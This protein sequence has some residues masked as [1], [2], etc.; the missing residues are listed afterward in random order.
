MDAI[1]LKT[2]VSDWLEICSQ[3]ESYDSKLSAE[4]KT[5]IDY[6]NN[7]LTNKDTISA[8]EIGK[9]AEFCEL[10]RRS[11]KY[12]RSDPQLATCTKNFRGVVK[13]MFTE[14]NFSEF[15][16][17]LKKT[18]PSSVSKPTG[19][20]Y[21]PRANV[22]TTFTPRSQSQPQAA[23]QPRPQT[24]PQTTPQPRPQQINIT[25][26]PTAVHKPTQQTPNP[27]N[28]STSGASVGMKTT[29]GGNRGGCLTLVIIIVAL[30]AIFKLWPT[31]IS[32]FT[33]NGDDDNIS[34]DTEYVIGETMNI[35]STPDGEII[36]KADYG[37]PV[38]VVEST[39]GEW[40]KVNANGISGY[41]SKSGLCSETEYHHLTALWG[42]SYTRNK[43]VEMRYRKALADFCV[44]NDLSAGYK[45]YGRE[46]NGGNIWSSKN[47]G[48][49]FI[50]D[51][52]EYGNR[53]A[54]V[55]S[56]DDNN[57]FK[58]ELKD[59]EVGNDKYIKRVT[60]NR[61][62]KY[63]IIYGTASNE[64]NTEMLVEE[65]Q[66]AKEKEIGIMSFRPG[67]R[68]EK[69][70][71][72]KI[73]I[74]ENSTKLYGEYFNPSESGR[75]WWGKGA[76]ILLED[77]QHLKASN[78]E[79]IPFEPQNAIFNQNQH[80]KFVL[81]FPPL[82]SGTTQFDFFESEGSSGWKFYDIMLSDAV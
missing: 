10:L 49:A 36:G 27:A 15:K 28:N 16:A 65:P 13:K 42:D 71:L 32:W 37:T 75:V 19:G 76:F 56:F 24:R 44:T 66:V 62:G 77:G 68:A 64:K 81:T 30:Y 20:T 22:Q 35:R 82:P 9:S 17:E 50:L 21:T 58:C 57:N 53:I 12:H 69:C 1:L 67:P 38:V 48:F 8:E 40:K 52:K 6:I 11:E 26:K 46:K 55:Y 39:L 47:V 54:A 25:P 7:L 79:G 41:I 59:S 29:S 3:L 60:V 74:S 43:V 23:P 45:L 18:S 73:V 63:S 51:Y 4:E 72:L 61:S 33:S 78:A 80:L 31:I 5:A 70:K 34:A 14:D 2:T